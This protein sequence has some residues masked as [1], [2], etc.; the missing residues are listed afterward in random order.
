MQFGKFFLQLLVVSVL[1]GLLGWQA[2]FQA[3]ETPYFRADYPS[4]LPGSRGMLRV[5]A[6]GKTSEPGDP[7]RHV[8]TFVNDL[9]Y[10]GME[11]NDLRGHLDGNFL[12]GWNQPSQVHVRLGRRDENARY[13]EYELFRVLHR[14]DDLRF[15]PETEVLEARLRLALQSGPDDPCHI[16]LY[17]VKKDWDPGGGGTLRNNNSPPVEG[18]VWWCDVAYPDRPWALPG[19]G[20]GSD[21]HPNADTGAMPL[22]DAIYTPGADTLEFASAELTRYVARRVRNGQ[23]L[24]FL[25]KL[26]D[27]AEDTPGMYVEVYSGNLGTDR[28]PGRRP[29]LRVTWRSATEIHGL[30]RE[31]FLEYGRTYDLSRWQTPGAFGFAVSFEPREGYEIPA[32]LIRGG[33]GA[34]SGLWM[35]ATL[36]VPVEWDWVDV[37]LA[38]VTDPHAPG[39]VFQAEI[40]DTW[41]RTAPP[42]TQNVVWTFSSPSGVVHT[43]RALYLGDHRWKVRFLP[44]EIGRWRYRWSQTFTE[45]PYESL[46]G[47]FDVLGGDG[48]GVRRGLAGLIERARWED[49]KTDPNRLDW[50]VTSLMRHER[51]ALQAQTPESFAS[52]AW[53]SYKTLLNKLRGA[54]N[55]TPPDTLPLV[56]NHPPRWARQ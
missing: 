44:D 29:Q 17:E 7:L 25:L 10:Q 52:D 41:V 13:G 21:D 24:L 55:Q 53:I 40:R 50:F 3:H 26:S 23:P 42:E 4:D 43:T 37:R 45:R 47:R 20:F 28:W 11:D 36:P 30:E 5:S 9:A 49:P 12:Y 14:W 27:Y 18:E 2:G 16:L 19:C 8:T 22:A 1:L 38:A 32:I 34:D 15:P 56:A 51:A 6:Y 46:V 35:P 54:I 48:D 39:D 33:V 31:I